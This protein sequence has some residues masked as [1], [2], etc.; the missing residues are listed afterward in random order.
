[1]VQATAP[2]TP[3]KIWVAEIEIEARDASIDPAAIDFVAL[4]CDHG[5]AVQPLA[6]LKI[7]SYRL[8]PTSRD[9][10]V[11][12][13][14]DDTVGFLHAV[15]RRFAFFGL[16]P[17]EMRVE[18]RGSKLEDFFRLENIGGMAPAERTVVALDQHLRELV[19]E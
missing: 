11:D 15:L 16:F 4:T 14:A 19:A 6:G 18:T 9:V 13:R 3:A 5:D 17:H 7:A 10:E 1:V 8:M 12:I 2:R